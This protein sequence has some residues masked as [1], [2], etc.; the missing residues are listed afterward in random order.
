MRKKLGLLLLLALCFFMGV[1][2]QSGAAA[3]AEI[4]LDIYAVNDF[5]GALRAESDYPGIAVLG[6]TLKKYKA[7][8]PTGT[9]ILG[10]GNMLFG[11]LES[12]ENDGMPVIAAMNEIGFAANVT[13]SHFFDFKPSVFTK[14]VQ[15]AKF[16]YLACNVVAKD[17]TALFKPYILLDKNGLKVAVV[18]VTTRST[19]REANPSN[20][21]NYTFLDSVASTQQ[22][23]DAAKKDG[24]QIVVALMHC[25]VKQRAADGALRGEAIELLNKLQGVDV[26][27]TGDSQTLIN[28]TYHNIPILQAGSHG[29]YIARVH[30]L[31]APSLKK[32]VGSHTD[33]VDV[34]KEGTSA[35][36]ILANMLQ[37]ITT[38]IDAKFGEVVA[39]NTRALTNDKFEQSTVAEY[40]TDVLRKSFNADFAI[41]N[42]G[43]FRSDLPVGPVTLRTLEEIYP[44][45]GKAV[46]L[47]M[48][49]K[50]I[51][52]ALDFGVDNMLVGQGRFSGLKIA[53]EPDL[54]QG[55]KVVDTELPDGSKLDAE[56]V[57]KVVTNDFLANGGDGYTMFKNAVS[58]TIVADNIKEVFHSALRAQET[59]DYTTD[60]RWSVG[61][62]RHGL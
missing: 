57:Y 5:R 39:T 18:G 16:A 25:G 24:A 48:K 53:V 38:A 52:K 9:I 35:D 34:V 60:Y 42:G 37:P 61:E 6:G 4:P 44:Y 21:E 59:I 56:K 49:G 27:F 8:N 41:I 26:C 62:I 33:M 11:T 47:F 46:L 55:Q 23:I 2:Q 17:G 22:A 36:P 54:P 32:V 1:R 45:R 29:K 10:G 31:Y 19:L 3:T 15:A 7:E 40:L 14:Q 30:L 58:R 12:D 43:A 13:G 28:S 51:L 50:D 20:L